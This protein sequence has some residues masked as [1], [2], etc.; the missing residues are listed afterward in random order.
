MISCIMEIHVYTAFRLGVPTKPVYCMRLK[1]ST[2]TLCTKRLR[3]F[4][5]LL[6]GCREKKFMSRSVWIFK[7]FC[8]ELIYWSCYFHYEFRMVC[9]SFGLQC[10]VSSRN[11]VTVFQFVFLNFYFY[12]CLILCNYVYEYLAALCFYANRH[13]VALS[14]TSLYGLVQL[15]V[16]HYIH[17]RRSRHD[18]MYENIN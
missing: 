13:F 9:V 4:F 2:I 12:F 6:F 16:F 3:I 8:V 5:S 14:H 18:W 17:G 1:M 10:A 11:F 7:L 15:I